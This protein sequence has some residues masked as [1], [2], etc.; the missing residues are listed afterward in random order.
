MH[1]YYS[2][3]HSVKV[4][5]F[6]ISCIVITAKKCFLSVLKFYIGSIKDFAT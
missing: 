4:F 2:V 5:C 6:R 3:E 1:G